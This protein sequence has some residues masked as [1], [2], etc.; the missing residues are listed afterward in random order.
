M[1]WSLKTI[2]TCNELIVAF[3]A[4]G[5]P[6]G[7]FQLSR[8]L[9]GVGNRL[10]LNDQDDRWYQYGVP[11]FGESVEMLVTSIRRCQQELA[12][13]RNVFIGSSMGAY[14]AMLYGA[15]MDADRVLAFGGE[16]EI[17]VPFS[18]S[19]LHMPKSMAITNR[20]IGNLVRQSRAKYSLFVGGADII[21]LY[22]ASLVWDAPNVDVIVVDGV[23]HFITEYINRVYPL[24]AMVM[25]ALEDRE[26]NYAT[27][28]PAS[29]S[30]D[31]WAGMRPLYMAYYAIRSRNY[32][33][34]V[35]QLNM[36]QKSLPADNE[37]LNLYRG[38]L[39]I[40]QKRAREAVPFL[41]ASVDKNVN[42]RDGW[43][44]LGMALNHSKNVEEAITAYQ[45]CIAIDDYA[46]GY[47][48]LGLIYQGIGFAEDAERCFAKAVELNP[49]NP[50]YQSLY[51]ASL[52]VA[53]D[54]KTQLLRALRGS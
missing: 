52:E 12:V 27:L 18:R 51:A 29:V 42:N 49:K 3:S 53:I 17:G 32:E 43:F 47:H 46:P 20:N 25:E 16:V 37:L 44:E 1:Y 31:F 7:K 21:D 54:T 38:M 11:G 2:P 6:A 35:E 45:K 41:K 30:G 4:M 36:A 26:T 10:F 23:G 24:R 13:Q 5:T 34:A 39:L 40:R 48:H 28:R 50:V 9:D 33:G 14:G 19:A 15:L 22:S 8:V